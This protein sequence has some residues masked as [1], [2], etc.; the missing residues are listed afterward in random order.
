MY[1]GDNERLFDGDNGQFTCQKCRKVS[2]RDRVSQSDLKICS[3]CRSFRITKISIT[4]RELL[5][6]LQEISVT[7][8]LLEFQRFELERVNCRSML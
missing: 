4:E 6:L 1:Q 8:N 3:N 2:I 7:L 5:E